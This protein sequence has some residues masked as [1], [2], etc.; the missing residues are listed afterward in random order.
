VQDAA[1]DLGVLER[2]LLESLQ[3]LGVADVAAAR[4][5][6][7]LRHQ[8]EVEIQSAQATL[9]SQLGE[10]RSLEAL[11][12][13][14]AL[15]LRQRESLAERLQ[16]GEAERTVPATDLDF[17][18]AQLEAEIPAAELEL[19]EWDTGLEA[20]RQEERRL[21]ESWQDA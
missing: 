18:E 16:L 17:R 2:T 15:A 19:R 10:H 5:A 13:A 4:E 21:G 20:L 1:E 8:L 9:A 6:V 3:A 12:E 14:G 7:A 11:Q